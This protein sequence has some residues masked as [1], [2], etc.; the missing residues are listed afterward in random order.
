VVP[1]DFSRSGADTLSLESPVQ[2]TGP[3]A[4]P[5]M[6]KSEDAKAAEEEES[7]EEEEMEEEAEEEEAAVRR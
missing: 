3:E 6:G 2:D 1:R 7:K 5:A 4:G